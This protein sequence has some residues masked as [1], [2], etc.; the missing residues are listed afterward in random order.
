VTELTPDGFSIKEIPEST[1]VLS[2][3]QKGF[4][5]FSM[6][7]DNLAGEVTI[8]SSNKLGDGK[9]LQKILSSEALSGV[10]KLTK[11]LPVLGDAIDVAEIGYNVAVADEGTRIAVGTAGISDT[12][13]TG[14]AFAAGFKAGG[15]GMARV[16]GIRSATP[17]GALL[18]GSSALATGIAVSYGYQLGVSGSDGL[19]IKGFT[20]DQ[21]QRFVDSGIKVHSETLYRDAVSYWDQQLFG[22]D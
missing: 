18:V 8:N 19:D 12:A 16:L 6:F 17:V 9:V 21:T 3:K 5:G 14:A 22:D 13:A 2:S 1:D 4:V 20:Q 11:H 7:V 15:I 10:G